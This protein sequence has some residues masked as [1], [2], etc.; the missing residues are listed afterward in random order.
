MYPFSLV[1][2][3]TIVCTS[4]TC[5]YFEIC[6]AFLSTSMFVLSVTINKVNVCYFLL[7]FKKLE[8][9]DNSSAM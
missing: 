6:P 8:K 3:V 5:F 2:V 9:L 4:K 7:V 1:G